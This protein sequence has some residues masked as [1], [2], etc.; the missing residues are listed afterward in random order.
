M[1]KDPRSPFIPSWTD[2][3]VHEICPGDVFG[4]LALLY[5]IPST[6]TR[7]AKI[8]CSLWRVGGRAFRRSMK[9]TLQGSTALCGVNCQYC[10]L[11]KEFLSSIPIFST[12]D[13]DMLCKVART[14]T[15]VSYERGERIIK[16]GMVGD[17]R[18]VPIRLMR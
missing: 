17:R 13:S 4:E 18:G 3:H 9:P 12:F 10:A 14:L 7:V 5:D 1:L 6:A 15:P 2:K 16:R 8:D 11:G